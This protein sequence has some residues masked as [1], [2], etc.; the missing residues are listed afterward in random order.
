MAEKTELDLE[1]EQRQRLLG[2]FHKL[3]TYDEREKVVEFCKG[4]GMVPMHKHLPKD[5]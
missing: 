3:G 2:Y 4:V 5:E 1:C